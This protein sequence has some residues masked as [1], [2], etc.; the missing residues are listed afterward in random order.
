MPDIYSPAVLNRVVQDLKN[1]TRPPFLLDRFFTET[2]ISTQEEIFFDVLTGKPRLAPF[3]SPLVEGQIVESLGYRT[4]S[5]KPAYV[6][7]KRVLEDGK[8]LKRPAGAPIYAPVDPATARQLRV[9]QESEDQLA[10]LMRRQEWMAAEIL[11]TG[12]VTVTGEKY[13]TTVVD[14]GRDAALT[15]TLAGAARWNDASPTPLDDLETW[16]G[17]VRDKS[18]ASVVDVV[19]SQDTWGAFRKNADVKALLGANGQSPRTN[20]DLGPDAQKFGFTD[21]GMVGDY[22]VWIHHDVYTA[23]D[24]TTQKY[25]PNGYLLM[26]SNQLEGVRHYGAIR[27]ETAGFQ[28]IDYF[29]KSWTVP[30]PAARFLM[31]Q[32]APLPVPYRINASLSAKVF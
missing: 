2:S 25:V 24:G 1:A 11:R 15:V 14:F 3:C 7:D 17:L 26:V 21:K 6:K 12:K 30:D 4:S 18:G 31:L 5:F 8:P 27:D 22:H 32:S 13:P 16:A 19:M 28:A 29:P 10:M 20:I 23:D 9:A